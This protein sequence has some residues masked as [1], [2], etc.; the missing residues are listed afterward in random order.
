MTIAKAV[1][2]DGSIQ[3][4]I[5]QGD[6]LAGGEV[7]PAT[8]TST[9]VTLTAALLA[10]GIYLANPAGAVT[11]TVDS[12]AN[13]IAGLI[14]GI[15]VTHIQNG[16]TF[17]WRAIITTAQTGTVSATAN[18]GITVN[19]GAIASNSWKEFLVTINNG[20]PVQTFAAYTT[21]ASAVVSGLTPAQLSLLSVGMIVT[22]SVNG[23]Q[24]TTIIAINQGAGTVTMSG[25]ANATA[26]TPVAITFSPVVTLDGLAP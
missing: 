3:R 14:G 22:N 6:L 2:F 11:W 24:G 23:L 13:I 4:Q 16:T 5:Q 8:S 10:A 1:I 15:G 7:V 21:N 12:A 18:T 20:T 9:A 19:R 25:N 17:R 26:A